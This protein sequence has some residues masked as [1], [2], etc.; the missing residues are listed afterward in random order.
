MPLRLLAVPGKSLSSKEAGWKLGLKRSE[1]A[2]EGNGVCSVRAGEPG[3]R[4]HKERKSGAG[5]S[6]AQPGQ[7]AQFRLAALAASD[8][9][10]NRQGQQA[11]ALAFAIPICILPLTKGAPRPSLR[12]GGRGHTRP[13]MVPLCSSLLA[14]CS[15]P[16]AK[17]REAAAAARQPVAVVMHFCT[18]Y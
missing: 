4:A 10:R 13:C 12:A 3:T 5:P 1:T 8:M 2:R 15:R 17:A 7:D 14:L 11:G 9:G 6:F 18:L 16:G